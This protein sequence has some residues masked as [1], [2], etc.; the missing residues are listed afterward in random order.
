MLFK[1]AK[2]LTLLPRKT[3]VVRYVTWVVQ[4]N[5]HLSVDSR[6]QPQYIVRHFNG[7][8]FTFQPQIVN[9]VKL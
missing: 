5:F 1:F 8:T 9:I 6:K 4:G 3:Q 2:K 7:L